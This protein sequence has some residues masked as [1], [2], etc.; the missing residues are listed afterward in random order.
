[1]ADG[2]GVQDTVSVLDRASMRCIH[3]SDAIVQPSTVPR[4]CDGGASTTGADG[5]GAST[6]VPRRRGY[7]VS[8]HQDIGSMGAVTNKPLF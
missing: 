1:M 7:G 3:R 5:D 4:R 2:C 8:W 6:T